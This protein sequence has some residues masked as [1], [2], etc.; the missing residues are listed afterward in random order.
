MK[1]PL[2]LPETLA[3]IAFLVAQEHLDEQFG[4]A[5]TPKGPRRSPERRWRSAAAARLREVADRLAPA[6]VGGPQCE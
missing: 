2:I 1:D 3:G 5:Q 4:R 6:P